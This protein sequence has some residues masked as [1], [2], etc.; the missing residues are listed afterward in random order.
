MTIWDKFPEF[1][2]NELRTLVAITARVLS[3]SEDAAAISSDV[4]DIPP[5]AAASDLLPELQ[6]AD[7]TLTASQIQR[8]LEDEDASTQIAL[9]ILGAVRLNAALADRIAQEYAVT[10][11]KLAV[12]ELLLLTGALVILAIKVKKIKW[13]QQQGEVT[14]FEATEP[15]K[16]FIVGLAKRF[17]P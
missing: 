11:T 3:E 14:F 2:T 16:A 4:M 1:S 12:P 5:R 9:E 6:R 15:V 10:E 7:P 13:G 8:A 17:M